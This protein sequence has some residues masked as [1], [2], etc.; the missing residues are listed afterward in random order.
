METSTMTISEFRM[1]CT[2]GTR[3]PYFN[4][5]VA[6]VMHIMY[7]DNNNGIGRVFFRLRESMNCQYAMTNEFEIR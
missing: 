5:I 7:I 1:A 2:A 4:G 3:K 6:D